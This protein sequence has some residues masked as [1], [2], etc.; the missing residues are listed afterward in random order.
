VGAVTYH[1]I[2]LCPA[3]FREDVQKVLRELEGDLTESPNAVDNAPGKG[4]R[5]SADPRNKTS[6]EAKKE[7]QA[8]TA[9][10]GDD[11]QP[12]QMKKEGLPP[13]AI[14]REVLQ[15]KKEGCSS[16]ASAGET[17]QPQE[18]GS[19]STASTREILQPKQ[20]G[21]VLIA[22]TREIFYP[23]EDGW[24]SAVNTMVQLN[25]RAPR[26]CVRTCEEVHKVPSLRHWQV[27]DEATR[28]EL[29]RT[30]EVVA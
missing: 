5:T 21:L 29:R 20:E 17:L 19:A 11:I 26:L 24:V 30:M 8:S 12:K 3:R 28:A 13:T 16:T 23:K 6:P 7:G 22:S 14:T 1:T 25:K 10:T 27:G 4:T 18:G 2:F 9:T 15:P